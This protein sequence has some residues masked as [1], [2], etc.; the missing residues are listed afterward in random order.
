MGEQ[1]KQSHNCRLCSYAC[2]V[3]RMETHSWR[4]KSK[5]LDA[6][7]CPMLPIC[8]TLSYLGT[9]MIS[10]G[11]MRILSLYAASIALLLA[12]SL[13]AGSRLSLRVFASATVASTSRLPSDSL[14]QL[15]LLSLSSSFCSLSFIMASILGNSSSAPVIGLSKSAGVTLQPLRDFQAPRG[16]GPESLSTAT[17]ASS[18]ADSPLLPLLLLLLLLLLLIMGATLTR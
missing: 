16:G 3:L 9:W 7:S 11:R 6:E 18:P 10:I 1:V 13:L 4:S 2:W 14:E 17:A 5:H 15:S 12:P 8:Q